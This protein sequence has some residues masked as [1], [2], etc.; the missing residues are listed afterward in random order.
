MLAQVETI[1]QQ[2]IE[3]GEMTNIHPGIAAAV[4]LNGLQV[5]YIYQLKEDETYEDIAEQQL[6][7]LFGG[8]K[9][10]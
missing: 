9:P 2:A 7:L 6:Q 4:I 5:I 1:L 10:S 3:Q 8:M